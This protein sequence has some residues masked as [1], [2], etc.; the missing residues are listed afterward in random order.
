MF[1]VQCLNGQLKLTSYLYPGQEEPGDARI[2]HA[3]IWVS[4]HTLCP[5][6]INQN[7]F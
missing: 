1:N 4:S 2:I 7:N 5:G 3:D 6:T